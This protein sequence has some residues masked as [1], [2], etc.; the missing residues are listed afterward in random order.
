MLA[1]SLRRVLSFSCCGR[2]K[3]CSTTRLARAFYFSTDSTLASSTDSTGSYNR[4]QLHRILDFARNDNEIS[5]QDAELLFQATGSDLLALA[6][7]ADEMRSRSAGPEVTYVVNRNI[8]FT[9]VCVKRCGFCAFSRTGVDHEGYFLPLDEILRRAD[10]ARSLGA[11]EVCIQAGLP[12]NMPGS[13]YE[14]IARSIKERHPDMHIHAFSPEEV[15]WGAKCSGTTVL[16]FLLRLKDAGVDSLPGTSAEILDNDLRKAVA[17]GRLSVEEW[18]HVVSTAHSLGFPTTATM[19]FGFCES[20]HHLAKHLVLLRD[21]QKK[22][23]ESQ[24]I[25]FTEF[26][27]LG[28][29]AAEAPMWKKAGSLPVRS[30]PTGA[31]VLRAHAVA[32]LVLNPKLP[33]GIRNVQVSWV[34][35]GFKTAQLMLLAGANDLGGTLMN[36]SISTAAGAQHG[37]LAKPADLRRLVWDLER[38]VAQR[39]TSYGILHRFDSPVSAS[40]D[41]ILEAE[42][43]ASAMTS[44]GTTEALDS[45][46]TVSPRQFGSFHQ[47][48]ASSEYRF[49]EATKPLRKATREP[50]PA[51]ASPGH[52]GHP[53]HPGSRNFSSWA[54]PKPG[55]GEQDVVRAREPARCQ[56]ITYSPSYTLVPTYEC[57]NVCSYCN[58]RKNLTK[59]GDWM[60]DERAKQKLTALWGQGVDEILV[61]AGEVHPLA[62]NRQAWIQRAVSIC[63]A[64]LDHG[65]LPH[66]NVG[67]LSRQEMQQLFAVNA[68]MGL[69]LETTKALNGPGAVHQFAPSKKP[70][71]RIAQLR[72]AGE[73]G[74]PFTTGLLIGIGETHSDR[75]HAL[76]TIAGLAQEF[77]HIQEVILQPHSLGSN[78]KL[79]PGVQNTQSSG[80]ERI[81]FGSASIAELPQL[82]KAARSILPPEVQIQVPPNLILDNFDFFDRGWQTLLQCLDNGAGDL[83]GISPRDE[84]NPDFSFPIIPQL[85]AA[86]A[87]E[88]YRLEARLPVYPQHLSWLSPRVQ[89][90]VYQRSKKLPD[91]ISESERSCDVRLHTSDR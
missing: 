6:L 58:F 29:V 19:M 54:G 47:L 69:M 61:M 34:K 8:N 7:T 37:Q 11:T 82:V 28:F 26:V 86:L 32:R 2:I 18:T 46:D 53:G 85:R 77:K 78:Q 25:G 13:L 33:G 83:G 71:L 62:S 20:P 70:S 48:I 50:S 30:G 59:Q 90:I 21:I 3:D 10:E 17:K 4:Q 75:L 81:L 67:P 51:S 41:A 12:P 56:T 49:L 79:K 14:S 66:T 76:E 36:E 52:P 63:S 31:E 42:K 87:K 91:K 38:P 16:D 68:S 44:I 40:W 43:K 55:G 5:S 57:F 39:T 22:A 65:F 72:Q 73:L 88:G 9:N 89:D 80:S 1:T 64:A 74:V 23:Q 45:L 24:Q 84:V 35:E 27:P 15:M 60:S